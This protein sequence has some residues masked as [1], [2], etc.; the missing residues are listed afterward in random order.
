MTEKCLRGLIVPL[1]A[2][3]NP[4]TELGAEGGAEAGALSQEMLACLRMTPGLVEA[5]GAA[6]GGMC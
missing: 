3:K 6:G 4:A 2:W 5:R 1:P